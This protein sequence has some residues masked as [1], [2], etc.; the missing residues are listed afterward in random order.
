MIGFN[1]S[2]KTKATKNANEAEYRSILDNLLG[3]VLTVLFWPD[4]PAASVLLGVAIK[5]M[6]I[7]GQFV[8]MNAS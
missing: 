8:Y 4:W 5:F 7:S 2:G 3:D 6:V 1:R